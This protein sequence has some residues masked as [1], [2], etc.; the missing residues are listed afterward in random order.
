[1][2]AAVVIA[3]GLGTRL[4]PLTERWAKPV[5]PVDGV[6]VLAHVLRELAAAGTPRVTVV[7]GHHAEQVERLCGDGSGFGLELLFARQGSP[8]GSAHAVAA[9]RPEPPYLVVGADTVFAPGELGRFCRAF[10]DSGAGGAIAVQD[11]PGTV[12]AV[13]GRVTRVLGTGA[14]AAPLWAVGREVAPLVAGLPGAPPHELAAAFQLA[15]DDGVHVAAV[16][17]APTRGLTTPHDLV[18]QNFA[19]L[20]GL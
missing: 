13:G 4:R 5:L 11:R 14:L 2:I 9:A 1:V 15:I 3:A 12:E 8:D 19:Y 20:G 17:V 7:T 6:P 18:E 10:A 16:E